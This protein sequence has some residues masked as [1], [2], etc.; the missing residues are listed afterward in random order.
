MA[1]W[2]IAVIA[3]QL[4]LLAPGSQTAAQQIDVSVDGCALLARAV[5]EEVSVAAKSAPHRAGPWVIN[6]RFENIAVCETA[7]RTVSKAFKLAMASAGINVIWGASGID[8]G[9]ICQSA[10]LSQCYPNRYPLGNT[11]GDPDAVFV[12]SSW[13][14][15]SRSVMRAMANPYSSDEVKFRPSE[16]KLRI[17]L[18]LRSVETA[19]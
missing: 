15:V 13:E 2:I 8:P 12:Q 11:S 6:P 18:A 5:Y 14:L 3:A 16:L 10:F 7:T 4:V 19:R 1:K 17:G 9:D